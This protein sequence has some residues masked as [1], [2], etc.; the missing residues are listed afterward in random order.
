MKKSDTPIPKHITDYLDW[1]DVEKGLS[2]TTQEN[3]SRFIKRFVDWLEKNDLADLKPHELSEKHVWDYRIYLARKTTS[4][5]SG[6]GLKRSTQQYYL[7]GLRSLLSFFAARDIQSLP[8]EKIELPKSKN[9]KQVRFLTLEQLRRLFSA[10]DVSTD[11]GRRDRAILETLFS[12]GMRISELTSLDR[13]QI[14]PSLE[15][16]DGL[17]LGIVGK[18]GKA[19]TVY[20]SPRALTWLK[21][22]L[23]TRDDMAPALF[24]N[25]RSRSDASR[26]LTARSIQKKVKTYA[27]KAGLPTDT[28][29]HVLRHSFATDL[30]GRGVDIRVLQE[31]LGHSSITATQIYTHVT[32]K[33]LKDIHRSYHGGNELGEE[34]EG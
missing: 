28:T 19:R 2:S 27:I 30:L 22:Y 14:E 20:F 10:P 25:Y 15:N 29:P 11:I 31:F 17:E 24:V 23:E 21:K 33:Q 8:P 32:S 5:Q 6:K 16:D 1:I 9:E 26:R 12:T 3:Y 34:D 13:E 4:G 7:I 18:G